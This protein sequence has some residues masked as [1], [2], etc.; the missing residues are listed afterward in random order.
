MTH[1]SDTLAPR[2]P[3][4]PALLIPRLAR[5]DER[6]STGPYAWLTP[7]LSSSTAYIGLSPGL[8]CVFDTPATAALTHQQVGML[9]FSEHQAWKHAAARLLRFAEERG[10]EEAFWVRD[11][12]IALGGAPGSL[13]R[14]VEV[15][16]LGWTAAG[17]VTHPTTFDALHSHFTEVLRPEHELLYYVADDNKLFVFDAPPRDVAGVVGWERLMRYSL[18]FPLLLCRPRKIRRFY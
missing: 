4:L 5:R 12:S 17:W 13:P 8:A 15:Q 3:E 2:A 1:F 11:A 10:P 9:G 14:G 18:G 7:G 6:Y 16:A